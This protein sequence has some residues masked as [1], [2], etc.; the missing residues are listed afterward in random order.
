MKKQ[1]AG[2]HSLTENLELIQKTTGNSKI[3][4]SLPPQT[5]SMLKNSGDMTNPQFKQITFFLDFLMVESVKS[6]NVCLFQ[7]LK[8][9]NFTKKQSQNEFNTDEGSV[10]QWRGQPF[11]FALNVL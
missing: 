4:E 5:N 8:I 2:S 6:C 7:H 10:R 9:L 1:I 11:I 3:I